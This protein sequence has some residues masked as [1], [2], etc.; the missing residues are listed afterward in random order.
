MLEKIKRQF[1]FIEW[2][3]MVHTHHSALMPDI[4]SFTY[5]ESVVLQLHTFPRVEA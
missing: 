2:I 3:T 5:Y 4:A 1:M